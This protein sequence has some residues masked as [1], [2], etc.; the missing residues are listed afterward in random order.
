MDALMINGLLDERMAWFMDCLIVGGLA[1][2]MNE[3][4]IGWMAG[5][6]DWSK[7]DRRMIKKMFGRITC[8]RDNGRLD[9][10]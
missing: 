8:W 4:M 3:S 9:Y 10:G 2:S 6:L 1:R 5:F 7:A